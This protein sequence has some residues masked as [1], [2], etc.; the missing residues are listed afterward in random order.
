MEVGRR[1]KR[2]DRE[3]QTVAD[4]SR[5]RLLLRANVTA[6]HGCSVQSAVGA[7]CALKQRINFAEPRR[8]W[9]NW[10]RLAR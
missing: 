7:F 2:A 3:R 9:D 10:S 5:R 8:D 1:I 6:P 4:K